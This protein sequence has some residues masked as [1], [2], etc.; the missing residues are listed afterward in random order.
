VS[1]GSAAADLGTLLAQR[2]IGERLQGVVQS[3]EL[4]R[5]SKEAIAVVE[6]AVQRVHLV[7]EAI[8]ALEDRIELAVVERLSFHAH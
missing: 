7:A 2:R 1:A 5:D 6:L 8:E 4:V 3:R